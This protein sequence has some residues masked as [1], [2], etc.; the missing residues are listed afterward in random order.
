MPEPKAVLRSQLYAQ[1]WQQSMVQ[2]AKSYAI[3]DV[4]L[5]KLCR[6]HDIPR[7][8]RGYWARKQAGQSPRQTPLPNPD[9]DYEI[10]MRD[11]DPLAGSPTGVNEELQKELQKGCNDDSPIV[12]AETMRGAHELVSQANQLLQGADKDDDG[13]IVMPEEAGLN[14]HVSKSTLRRALL[15]LDA[16]LKAFE[17]RGYKVSVGPKVRVMDV[18]VSFGISETL[19]KNAR[20]WMI[21]ISTADTTFSIAGTR[22]REYLQAILHSISPGRHCIGRVCAVMRGATPRNHWKKDYKASS[23]AS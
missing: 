19:E 9:E 23:K 8:A 18:H 21:T 11:P 2:L 4:G 15:I 22:R 20:N 3:S 6:K 10:P 5:A 7:P 12:V 14:L 13:F 16:V 17:K 1:V